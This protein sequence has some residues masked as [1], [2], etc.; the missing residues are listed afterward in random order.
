[1]L[2]QVHIPQSVP[3][4]P[5]LSFMHYSDDTPITTYRQNSA[6]RSAAFLYILLSVA[7]HGALF[8]LVLAVVGAPARSVPGGAAIMVDTLLPALDAPR[9]S[10]LT[11][12]K[13]VPSPAA[14]TEQATTAPRAEEQQS[15]QA[16]NPVSD[17]MSSPLGLGMAYGYVRTLADGATLRDDIRRYYFELVNAINREWWIRAASLKEPIRQDGMVEIFLLRDGTV[18]SQRIRQSTGSRDSDRVLLE[19]LAAASPFPPLPDQYEGAAF[20]APLRIAAP[21]ALFR[22]GGR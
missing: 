8:G 17:V 14:V 10:P 21:S 13:A 22:M 6:S 3:D 20:M 4:V 19:A 7:L 5:L 2:Y 15:V 9:P 11:G 16:D 1:M 18:M 12:Q